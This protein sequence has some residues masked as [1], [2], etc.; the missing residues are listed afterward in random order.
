MLRGTVLLAVLILIGLGSRSLIDGQSQVGTAFDVASVKPNKQDPRQRL[1]KFGCSEG[2]FT[3]HAQ[4]IF[5]A[6]PWAYHVESFQV[7]GTAEWTNSDPY[8]IDAKAQG[9]V[10][11]DQCRLMV[12][13]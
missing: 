7:L 12:R 8:D 13:A 9:P 5:R 3:S 11:E 6:I 1:L 2:A 4:P 10:S